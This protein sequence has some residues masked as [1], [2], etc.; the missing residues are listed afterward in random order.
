MNYDVIIHK[1][2]IEY[3]TNSDILHRQIY[4]KWDEFQNTEKGI[5]MSEL[6]KDVKYNIETMIL[7]NPIDFNYQCTFIC[8]FQ[9]NY[10]KI[11]FSL[12]I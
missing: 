7:L 3:K 9:N 5:R 12:S 11:Q 4:N 2:K 8:R 10:D 6:L 1:C